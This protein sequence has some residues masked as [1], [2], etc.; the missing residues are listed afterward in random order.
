[1]DLDRETTIK[2]I[3]LEIA[4]KREQIEMLKNTVEWLE[5][6]HVLL[7]YDVSPGDEIE[8][9]GRLGIVANEQRGVELRYYPILKGSEP[10]QPPLCSSKVR[11]VYPGQSIKI[12]SR[13]NKGEEK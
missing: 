13:H 12:V 11:C 7:K 9:D 8:H 3:E 4:A 5:C 6:K 10:D 1:M 2:N